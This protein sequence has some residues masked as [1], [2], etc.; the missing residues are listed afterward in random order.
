MKH[1]IA[2][3]SLVFLAAACYSSSHGTS[4]TG[5]DPT[6]DTTPD[7]QVDPLVD[8][9]PD[10]VD[11]P[12]DV[13]VEPDVPPPQFSVTFVIENA[14]P[15]ECSSCV[16][17][18]EYMYYLSQSYGLGI[19]WNDETIMWE[20]PFCMVG[21]EGLTDPMWCCIDCAA[22]M[23]A[24]QQIVPGQSVR[25]PWYGSIF[26]VDSEVCD[27]GCYWQNPAPPGR[28]TAR[29]CAYPSYSCY[30]YDDCTINEEGI[31]P[32]AEAEGE[33]ICAEASFSFPADDGGEV[34]LRIQ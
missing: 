34:Y 22:P 5:T 4:D 17:Y 15:L 30:Y 31:I 21:C 3:L 25:M 28:G 23:P 6:A 24:V 16:Y 29:V 9:L 8:P 1:L 7:P 32:M 13:P 33:P 11:V 18:L 12:V 26:T 2:I 19:T 14:A 20:T 10:P 27:C